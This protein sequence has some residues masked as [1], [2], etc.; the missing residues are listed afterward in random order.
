MKNIA[1]SVLRVQV[2]GEFLVQVNTD[3]TKRDSL[4]SLELK[5]FYT[6]LCQKGF[7]LW[8]EITKQI[9]QIKWTKQEL[10]KPINQIFAAKMLEGKK[11]GK[12]THSG[13]WVE[14]STVGS[15]QTGRSWPP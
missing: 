1:E 4:N 11:C 3:Q 10:L 12:V 13:P 8:K 15:Y 9:P 7:I 2:I 5:E 6:N 14:P